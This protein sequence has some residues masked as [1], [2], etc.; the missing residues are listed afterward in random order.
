MLP[1]K[2]KAEGAHRR[3]TI[4]KSTGSQRLDRGFR[5]LPSRLQKAPR[6]VDV[7]LLDHV[8]HDEPGKLGLQSDLTGELKTESTETRTQTSND[9]KVIKAEAL[10]VTQCSTD[11]EE[12][13]NHARST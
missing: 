13:T 2:L 5:P 9:L 1:R 4:R 12:N 6:C 11:L 8:S 10:E 7:S 3:P